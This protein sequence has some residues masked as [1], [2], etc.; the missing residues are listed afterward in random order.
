MELYR[1]TVPKD[2]SYRVIEAMGHMGVCHFVDLNK[3]VQPFNLPYAQ[4]IKLC[5][6]ADRRL[7]YLM[8]KCKE[9]R[10][11][12]HRPSNV[13]SYKDNIARISETKQ[14]SAMLLFDYI[15]AEVSQNA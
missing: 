12:I 9:M 2:D 8:Q 15:D 10:V 7:L 4:R 11:R 3:E 6:D 1:V 14:K 13:Q 5:D